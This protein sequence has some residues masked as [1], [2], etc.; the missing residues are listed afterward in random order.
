MKELIA[1]RQGIEVVAVQASPEAAGPAD[2][3]EVTRELPEA[4][5]L[6]LGAPLP[7]T[8]ASTLIDRVPLAALVRLAASG[9][10]EDAEIA[11]LPDPQPLA[12]TVSATLRDAAEPRGPHDCRAIG[13]RS[14]G[15]DRPPISSGSCGRSQEWA[16]IF[17]W[18]PIPMNSGRRCCPVGSFV[19]SGMFR[20]SQE[21]EFCYGH[22][23]LN[24]SG[25][26]RHLHGHNGRAVI[27]M[28]GAQ[29]DDRGMLI[30]FGDI[31]SAI[32]TWIDDELDHRMILCERDPAA[33]FLRSQGGRS[34]RSRTDPTAENIARLIYG[35]RRR[36]WLSRS[37]R[38]RSRRRPGRMRRTGRSSRRGGPLIRRAIADATASRLCRRP[39][40]PEHDRYDDNR[41]ATTRNARQGSGFSPL[42]I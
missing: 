25:K 21:I 13:R 33:A 2:E 39:V 4:V 22:R 1:I 12:S 7:P 8:V 9:L 28:E 5:D 11:T 6:Y 14:A 17:L 35:Y 40:R 15:T 41:L 19:R 34:S 24:Y 26:C 10:L 3:M 37:W 30:D 32:R 42:M 31:K 23:L 16:A 36:P 18:R 27:V 38:S 29:L 20:V